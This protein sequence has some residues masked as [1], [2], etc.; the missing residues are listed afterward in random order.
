MPLVLGPD[1]GEALAVVVAEEDDLA[2]R[3]PRRRLRAARE[4]P[5]VVRRLLAFREELEEPDAWDDDED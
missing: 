1:G 2:P 5:A 4:A 3:A